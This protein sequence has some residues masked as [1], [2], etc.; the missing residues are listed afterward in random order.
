MYSFLLWTEKVAFKFCPTKHFTFGP[1]GED[2]LWR[3]LG[4]AEPVG[5]GHGEHV[6]AGPLQ[7]VD[8]VPDDPVPG[9]GH[10]AAEAELGVLGGELAPLPALRLSVV[11]SL[12]KSN[13][14]RSLFL[15]SACYSLIGALKLCRSYSSLCNLF[16]LSEQSTFC[17]APSPIRLKGGRIL[18][19]A[20]WATLVF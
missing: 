9:Q 11:A 18:N 5:R 4:P 7:P 10:P 6:P 15:S 19:L 17:S 20:F 2:K 8:A 12:C 13:R 1:R 3:L 16:S 14:S